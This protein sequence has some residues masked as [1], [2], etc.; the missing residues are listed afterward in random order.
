ME[1]INDR[2]DRKIVR[3]TTVFQPDDGQVFQ[4]TSYPWG[5]IGLVETA[6]ENSSGVVIGP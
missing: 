3:P 5:T 4:D 6:R 2:L 1:D